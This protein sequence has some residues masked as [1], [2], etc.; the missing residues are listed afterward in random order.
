MTAT[1]TRRREGIDVGEVDGGRRFEL[2]LAVSTQATA[3]FGI[4]GSGKTV[5]ATVLVEEL[6]DRGLPVAIIDPT[7]VWW[8][9][10]SSA[11]GKSEGYPVV[12]LGGPHGDLPLEEHNGWA[13]ADFAVDERVPLIL[14]LR[15][16]RK[17]GQRRFV[18]DFCE[19]LY[20]RK[21]ELSHR[22][23]HLVAI[24]EA[25]MFV[26]QKVGRGEG[27]MVEAVEDLVRR[28]RSA[29]IGVALMDGRPASVNKDVLAFAEVLVSHRATN[30]HDGAALDEWIRRHDTEGHRQ[31]FLE[32]LP[33][34]PRGSAWFWSPVLD[35]F[36]LVQVRMRRTYDS[37][38]TPEIDETPLEPP[39]AWAAPDLGALQKLLEAKGEAAGE[40]EDP[41]AL[42]R[43]VREL[44]AALARRPEGSPGSGGKSDPARA[45]LEGRLREFQA[46]KKKEIEQ[47]VRLAVAPLEEEISA[48]RS[49]VGE[50][51]AH[52]EAGAAV[53]ESVGG[54]PT[55]GTDDGS[56][57]DDTPRPPADAGASGEE[58]EA[59]APPDVGAPSGP[60]PS[61]V[62]ADK[63]D[64]EVGHESGR[65]P[66]K[67]RDG[68]RRI[69]GALARLETL[70]ISPVPRAT[71]A[72]HA[73]FKPSKDGG[74]SGTFRDYLANMGREE[75]L[76]S[77]GG[78]VH[79]TD[80]GRD[81]AARLG[82]VPDGPRDLAEFHGRLISGLP[83]TAAEMLRTII[84]RH[85][86]GISR[87]EL[88]EECNV[89]LNG[90]TRGYL[91]DFGR[92]GLVVSKGGRVRATERLF[93]EGLS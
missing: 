50:A 40:E 55:A 88:A 93:P 90:T 60:P 82:A 85:P 58:P 57:E 31:R 71:L 24:D 30:P 2:P 20:F 19:Q 18:T 10:K 26:P 37:S 16:L 53:L 12:V 22:V 84:A 7:D 62:R 43:Q 69:L 89:T 3:I 67:K 11:D 14:S 87:Q 78:V 5:T 63:T 32:G 8:G 72:A 1:R 92:L 27:R 44:E 66:A 52:L 61:A 21:G 76:V 77:D 68:R 48:L 42:R 29:G 34:L 91:A 59:A 35:V 17:E 15:H 73:D 65:K 25:S 6:L 39:E 4:R 80:D 28:G 47:A 83:E 75:V 46:G 54:P 86:G 23:P 79:L 36:D 41:A 49:T 56:A 33:S 13:L 64:G 38:R 70:G 45:K 81:L 51:R 74:G 9:L